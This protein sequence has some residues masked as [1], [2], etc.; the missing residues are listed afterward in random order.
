MIEAGRREGRD[1]DQ[2][3]FDYYYT[4]GASMIMEDFLNDLMDKKKEGKGRKLGITK[5]R[6][7]AQKFL[8]ERKK[9]GKRATISKLKKHLEKLYADY[10]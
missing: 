3:K 2:Y 5:V 6:A 10:K 1:P 7:A 4:G 8:N 9:K